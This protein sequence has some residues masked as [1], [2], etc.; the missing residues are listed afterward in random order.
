[1]DEE[2]AGLA[3]AHVHCNL[4][5][6]RDGRLVTEDEFVEGEVPTARVLDLD[7]GKLFPPHDTHS[8][9]ARGEWTG[10]NPDERPDVEEML[11]GVDRLDDRTRDDAHDPGSAPR[12][13]TAA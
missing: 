8:I 3:S 10:L 11:K 9:I 12:P 13:P 6:I 4:K 5:A 7:Q 2:R 1:M